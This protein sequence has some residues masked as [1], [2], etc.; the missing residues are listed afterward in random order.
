MVSVTEYGDNIGT[1]KN[2]FL[3]FRQA[4]RFVRKIINLSE[5]HYEWIGPY[6]WC[7]YEKEEYIKIEGE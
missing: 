3:D 6:L 1:L 7:C 2:L 5:N 4:S